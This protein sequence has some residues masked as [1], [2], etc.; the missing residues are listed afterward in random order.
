MAD[1]APGFPHPLSRRKLL[2]SSMT[3]GGALVAA[4]AIGP[5][6]FSGGALAQSGDLRVGWVRATTGRLASSY[7]AIYAGGLVAIEEINAKGG[8][9]GRRIVAVEEDDEGSPAKQPAIVRKLK[10]D[11]ID[12]IV[13]PAGASQVLSS[14]A[15]S[16]PAKM[17]QCG[18]AS[19]Q[20]VGDATKYPYNYLLGLTNEQ[21]G[22]RAAAY[23]V[24]QLKI[25]KIGIL[26]E[27][28]PFGE[29]AQLASRETIKKLTGQDATAVQ[30]YAMTASDLSAQ[31]GN[32]QK[33]GCEGLIIWMANN[34][35]VGMAFNGME[36]MNWMVPSIGHYT[37]FNDALF[38]IVPASA[39]KNVYAI[40][41]KNWTY[42]DTQKVSDRHLSLAR[43]LQGYA[44]TKGTE[45]FVAAMPQYD[46][47]YLLKQVVEQEKSFDVEAIKRGMDNVKNYDALIGKISFSPTNHCGI[48]MDDITLASVASAKD[49]RSFVAT[50]L[51]APGA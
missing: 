28:T 24:E 31:L 44:Y 20:T 48:S 40:F 42:T 45:P 29:S 51:R 50:R 9:M 18:L 49:P 12:I 19:P 43:K 46:F 10:S 33:A 15:S 21:E 7:A 4:A 41:F 47:L 1:Q 37:L 30:T 16:T 36:R 27:S 26:Y 39:M 14:L 34:V 32:L 22:A 35:H 17:I 25:R 11:N 8:I 3:H 6:L 23:M 5:T 2:T 13:G 38:D